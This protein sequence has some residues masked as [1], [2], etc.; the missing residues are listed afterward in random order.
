MV[1][2]RCWRS[3]GRFTWLIISSWDPGHTRWVPL[4]RRHFSSSPPIRADPPDSDL[5]LTPAEKNLL[6]CF[7]FSSFRLFLQCKNVRLMRSLII[8]EATGGGRAGGGGRRSSRRIRSHG[9]A[10]GA[11]CSGRIS[12]SASQRLCPHE[13]A[14]SSGTSPV[15]AHKGNETRLLRCCPRASPSFSAGPR[16]VAHFAGALHLLHPLMRGEQRRVRV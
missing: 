13:S 15:R 14:E 6:L 3:P 8:G 7:A 11:A 12:V 10:G 9:A 5:F 2:Q 1:Q 16:G 4:T